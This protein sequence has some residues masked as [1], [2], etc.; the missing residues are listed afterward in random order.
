MHRPLN[1]SVRRSRQSWRPTGIL[2]AI[3]VTA[4]S[5]GTAY[6]D[7][8]RDWYGGGEGYELL[9][10]ATTKH[11]GTAAGSVKS[12]G[13]KDDGF[14]TLTQGFKAEKYKGKR[15][16]LS[17]FVKSDEVKGW[18]GLWMRIDGKEKSGIA[19]DNMNDRA[20]KGTTDWKMYE[21]VLDVPDD[22]EEIFFGFLVAG[23]GQGWVDDMKIEEVGEDVATTGKAIEGSDRNGGLNDL[24]KDPKNLDFEG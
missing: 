15:V 21:V 1:Y 3:V 23:K 10:D 24:P 9:R 5:I 19:F 7:P 13:D 22:A 12:T 17:A 18:A 4:G 11:G 20:V 6:A 16:R 8:P 2:A 14:G